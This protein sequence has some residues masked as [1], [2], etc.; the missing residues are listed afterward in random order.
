MLR[1]FLAKG[2]M[3]AIEAAGASHPER[4]MNA[5]QSMIWDTIMDPLWHEQNDIKYRKDNA[6]DVEDDERLAAR[7]VWYVEHRYELLAHHDQFLAEI[8]LTRLS[9]MRR[10]MKQRWIQHLDIAKRAW[11]V[12][13][14]QKTTKQHVLTKF[15]RRKQSVEENMDT[16][17]G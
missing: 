17:F 1:G 4:Q 6:Y 14:E 12:E 7:I 10:E 5:L 3:T 8:D 15:F 9:R 13:R 11:E 16:D 2:W